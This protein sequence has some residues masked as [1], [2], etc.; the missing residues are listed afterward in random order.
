[1]N[2][3]Q[4]KALEIAKATMMGDLRDVCLDIFKHPNIK[5]K[6]WKDMSE[7][8]QRDVAAM[9]ET[10]CRSAVVKAIDII[11]SEGRRHIKVLLKQVTVKDA[12]KGQFECSKHSDLRYDLI[13]AQGD[14]V[15]VVLTGAEKYLG[16]SR[17]V[18]FDKDQPSLPATEPKEST[19]EKTDH[20]P[21]TG[22]VI[23]GD[24]DEDDFE[25]EEAE[26]LDEEDEDEDNI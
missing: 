25:N 11:S 9:V 21:E 15:L 18:K 4:E 17:R 8:E 7:A 20:D 23:E 19:N 2:K 22:E 13:D 14:N 5:G 26:D 16:E 3:R 24:D 6:A 10:K 12:I 1:M